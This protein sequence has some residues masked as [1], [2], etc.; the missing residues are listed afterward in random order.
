MVGYPLL[1]V[2]MAKA[3]GFLFIV[4]GVTAF[5]GAVASIN[6]IWVFGPYTPTQI[7]AGSQPDWYMGWLDG[8]VRM[9]PHLS[10]TFWPHHLLE[11]FD[12]R[13]DCSGNYVYW[14]STL[15]IH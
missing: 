5:L 12:P 8:L 15:A 2:Y 6:P 1:P 7:S 4:F 13:F 11:Y 10:H 9:S 14:F 3:G